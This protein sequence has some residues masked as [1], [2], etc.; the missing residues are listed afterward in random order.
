[1][2]ATL[3]AKNGIPLFCLFIKINEVD[4]ILQ[5]FNLLFTTM[6]FA[7]QEWLAS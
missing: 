1:L 2:Q 5:F 6:F 7:V 4:Q 3:L